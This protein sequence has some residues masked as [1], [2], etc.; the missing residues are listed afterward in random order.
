MEKFLLYKK[1]GSAENFDRALSEGRWLAEL[2]GKPWADIIPD[3]WERLFW[4]RPYFAFVSFT[5][6][7]C[8]KL[9]L[10]TLAE[11]WQKGRLMTACPKCGGTSYIMGAEFRLRLKGGRW[12][13]VCADCRSAV[14][15]RGPGWG[16][17]WRLTAAWLRSLVLKREASGLGTA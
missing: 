11:S 12:F 14:A 10:G 16:L 3:Q 13:G 5:S 2:L 8:L 4:F 15:G 7:R 17:A 6:G 1:G 9:S